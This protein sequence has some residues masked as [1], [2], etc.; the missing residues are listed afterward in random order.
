MQ[1][2]G[3]CLNRFAVVVT[4]RQQRSVHT[5]GLGGMRICVAV[6]DHQGLR[7]GDAQGRTGRQQ[8]QGMRFAL[9]QGVATPDTVTEKSVQALQ[10]K[11]LS[12]MRLWLIGHTGETNPSGL[13]TRQAG[14][15]TG[16]GGTVL[17]VD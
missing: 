15:N 13:P 7:G 5:R 10:S 1:H 8:W 9:R 16:E 17:S 3:Q 14:L 4:P 6:A 12:G 2:R 11:Q